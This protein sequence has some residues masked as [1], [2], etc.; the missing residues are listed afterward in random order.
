MTIVDVA[1]SHT[2]PGVTHVSTA[3]LLGRSAFP[4]GARWL[5]GVN[6]LDGKRVGVPSGSRRSTWHDQRGCFVHR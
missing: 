4:L 6:L 2:K 5:I 3:V 1:R